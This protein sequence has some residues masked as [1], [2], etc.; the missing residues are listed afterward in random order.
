MWRLAGRLGR[1]VLLLLLCASV[2]H[3]AFG[4]TLNI[5]VVVCNQLYAHAL[6]GRMVFGIDVSRR[7]AP[8]TYY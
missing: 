7:I 5:L 8:T 1:W 2:A 6:D 3:F 4:Y